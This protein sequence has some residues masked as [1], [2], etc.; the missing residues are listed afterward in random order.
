MD[1]HARGGQHVLRF[2]R[3]G[4]ETSVWRLSLSSRVQD[5][6][7]FKLKDGELFRHPLDVQPN[8][9][10]LFDFVKEYFSDAPELPVIPHYRRDMQKTRERQLVRTAG[11]QGGLIWGV[12]VY[13]HECSI[14]FHYKKEPVVHIEETGD[15]LEDVKI[16]IEVGVPAAGSLENLLKIPGAL[17]FSDIMWIVQSFVYDLHLLTSKA[18]TMHPDPH[19]GNIFF[20]RDP[21]LHLWWADW[22]AASRPQ[23]SDPS[24]EDQL[25]G[26]ALHKVGYIER[27][28]ATDSCMKKER[29]RERLR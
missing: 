5:G 14:C 17:T 29:E 7:R 27:R 20:T 25:A 8:D 4:T 19:L 24:S 6:S 15:Q 9:A 1:R 23:D 16:N 12:Y 18:Y 13:Q 26:E 11:R 22:S 3:C 2:L 28:S 10:Q 21:E